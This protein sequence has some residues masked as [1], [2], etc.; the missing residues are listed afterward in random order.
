MSNKIQYRIPR[1]INLCANIKKLECF[2][3]LKLYWFR[4]LITL[5]LIYL[6]IK[7]IEKQEYFCNKLSEK[8]EN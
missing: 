7:H 3:L 8:W 2:L 6:K 1:N 5:Q 4:L